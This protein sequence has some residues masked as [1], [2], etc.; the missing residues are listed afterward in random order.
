[1]VSWMK[2]HS[3]WKKRLH[4]GRRAV[5]QLAK[6][7]STGEIA[8]QFDQ[9]LTIEVGSGAVEEG[10]AYWKAWYRD[11][12]KAAAAASGDDYVSAGGDWRD[13]PDPWCDPPKGFDVEEA[14]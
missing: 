5:G 4:A 13:K 7:V 3:F 6:H 8:A 2:R 1:M 9:H 10:S 14:E 12:A 11:E